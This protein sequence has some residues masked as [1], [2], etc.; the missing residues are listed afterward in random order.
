MHAV[1]EAVGTVIE[2]GLQFSAVQ[3]VGP[4]A[5]DDDRLPVASD[6]VAHN[7]SLAPLGA[8]RVISIGILRLDGVVS[9]ALSD[10]IHEFTRHGDFEFWILAER[11]A[12]GV[13]ESLGHERADA[14][15]A[16]DAS[17]L[18]EASLGDAQMQGEVHILAVHGDHEPPDG[19]DHDDDVGCLHR[20]DHV[21]EILFDKHPEEFHHTLDHSLCG[22]AVSAHDAVTQ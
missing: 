14:D 13:A 3:F 9:L 18:A 6:A 15:G 7:D 8:Q 2:V 11:D 12:Y 19:F 10:I 22:V 16:L 5:G 20:D 21:K 4:V 17:I 1:D